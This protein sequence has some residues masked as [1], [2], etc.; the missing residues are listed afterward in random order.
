MANGH[1]VVGILSVLIATKCD[2]QESTWRW[3]RQHATLET[4]VVEELPAGRWKLVCTRFQPV[5]RVDL[6]AGKYRFE[7]AGEPLVEEAAAAACPSYLCTLPAGGSGNS[8]KLAPLVGWGEFTNQGTAGEV[9][10]EQNIRVTTTTD[11]TGKWENDGVGTPNDWWQNFVPIMINGQSFTGTM[12]RPFSTARMVVAHE[13]V[14]PRKLRLKANARQECNPSGDDWFVTFNPGGSVRN[15]AFDYTWAEFELIPGDLLG[16]V[17]PLTTYDLD[18]IYAL[19]LDWFGSW[20]VH[21]GVVEGRLTSM[22]NWL[23]DIHEVLADAFDTSASNA[24]APEIFPPSPTRPNVPSDW[25]EGKI[26]GPLGEHGMEFP[27]VPETPGTGAIGPTWTVTIPMSTLQEWFSGLPSQWV[28]TVDLTWFNPYRNTLH[29]IIIAF[30]S[31]WGVGRV[32]GEL[33]RV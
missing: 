31:L 22:N 12:Q 28:L 1:L 13:F 23:A 4:I 6:G 26:D 32:W 24:V 18:D 8:I 7:P 15:T 21:K 25:F 30:F 10:E 2:A 17:S 5:T 11:G 14:N 19:L 27:V 9:A 16:G 29:V 3:Y 33:R 20:T